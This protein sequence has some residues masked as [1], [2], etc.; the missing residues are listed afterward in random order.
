[1][2]FEALEQKVKKFL[3][4]MRLRGERQAREI[5]NPNASDLVIYYPGAGLDIL[6]PLFSTD[7]QRF[8]SVDLAEG[9]KYQPTEALDIIAQQ[10]KEHG[11]HVGKVEGNGD[12][13][14]RMTFD[15]KGR[16]RELIYYFHR[17]VRHFTP[18]EINSGYDVYFSKRAG[19]FNNPEY[20]ER[21]INLMRIGGHFLSNNCD[22]ISHNVVED[23][24][25]KVIPTDFDLDALGLKEVS[26]G[27]GYHILRKVRDV[28]N[29]RETL[30]PPYFMFLERFVNGLINEHE[31]NPQSDYARPDGWRKLLKERVLELNNLYSSLNPHIQIM[32]EPIVKGVNERFERV[33]R[34]WR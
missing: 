5:V 6:F 14:Y 32:C 30:L 29:A 4:N 18:P 20:L 13:A 19:A 22:L 10:I 7:G 16:N 21:M 31:T 8:I 23:G 1:M 33:V 28:P 15:F 24:E 17:D 25:T 34:L 9:W 11:G 12:D 26:R 2:V 27:N 3:L